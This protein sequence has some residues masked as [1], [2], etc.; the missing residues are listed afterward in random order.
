MNEK[1]KILEALDVYLPDVDGV[2]T[3]LHNYSTNMVKKAD[4]TVMVPKNKRGYVDKQPYKVIRCNSIHI[5]VLNDYYGFPDGD[6]KFKKEIMAGEYDIIHF[7]SPF[8]MAKFSISTAKKKNIPV[9]ATY[10]SNM[11]AIIEDVTKS[12]AIA[13]AFDKSFG[14]IYNKCDEVFVCSPM[15]EA[16]LRKT[17]Y[18]GKVTLMP[19]GTDFPRCDCIEENI[20]KANEVFKLDK[21]EMVFIYVGRIMKLKRIDFILDSLKLVKNR[22]KKFKFFIVG[23]GAELNKLKKY[24]EKLGFTQ[25]E[26][27]FTGFLPREHFPLIF[28]R[29]NLLLFPSLYDNFGLVKLEG[30]SYETPGLFIQ[31]SCASYQVEDG[32]NGYLSQDSV[33]CFASKIVE[34]MENPAKLK[35]VGKN[36]SRDL[37]MSWEECSDILLKRLT[38][39]A[40]EHKEKVKNYTKKDEP[41]KVGTTKTKAKKD[42]VE[43][44]TLLK[45]QIKR[46]KK[47]I[48]D[49]N[50]LE[51]KIVKQKLMSEAKLSKQVASLEKRLNKQLALKE[52][53]LNKQAELKQ[54][55]LTKQKKTIQKR[56]DKLANKD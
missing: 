40:K 56:K 6:S 10:H 26:V 47:L 50:N 9:V 16:Q 54:K 33:Y 32:V 51:N 46:E 4:V 5:P 34:I 30:A 49:L 39:I 41:K 7:H 20:Q 42:K 25:D 36:A 3:A 24:A 37:Y 52:E 1:L 31:D 18:K 53:R 28:S 43:D 2:I 12:S 48:D 55:Q 21:D 14:K 13:D 38:E 44:D 45:Q 22:G 8:N 11:R 35:D 15:V 19:F 17:G 29:A 23:K 27:I